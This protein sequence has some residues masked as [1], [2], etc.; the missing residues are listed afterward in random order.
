VNALYRGFQALEKWLNGMSAAVLVAMMLLVAANVVGRYVFNH[1]ILGT[2]EFTEFFMVA[3]V[4]LALSHTQY[5]KAHINITLVTSLLSPRKNL[6]CNLFTYMIGFLFFALI[7]WQGTLMSL[8]SY[9]M[10]EVTF[11]TIEILEWPCKL[12]VPFGSMV[13]SV[14]FLID[15][16]QTA[17]ELFGREKKN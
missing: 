2:L 17:M 7:V 1:P 8:E 14:R 13:I 10:E 15:T 12:F 9:E 6:I 4:Y 5:L 11:G 3:A 16:V